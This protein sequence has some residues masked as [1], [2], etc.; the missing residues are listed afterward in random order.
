MTGKKGILYIIA[1]P[2]GNLEDI[3]LRALKVLKDVDIIACEDTRHT[4][5]LLNFYEIKKPLTSYFEHNKVTKGMFIIKKLIEGK[6][7]GLVSNAGCPGISDPGSDIVRIAREHSITVTMIPG[8]C[9]FITAFV[10]SGIS[11]ERF[12]FEGFLPVRKKLRKQRFSAIRNETGSIVLYEAPHKLLKTIKDLYD[13]L[14]ERNIIIARELT[15]KYE[16]VLKL[17]LSEAIKKYEKEQARGE[18]VITIEGNSGEAMDKP[19]ISQYDRI[20]I[21]KDVE[22]YIKKGI[23]K[24]DAIK[25]TAS[26][27]GISKRDVYQI[28]ESQ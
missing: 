26:N 6:N 28:T 16:E 14:G 13:Y 15:K 19:L 23:T 7:I 27:R 21:C 18:F 5:K 10:L 25:M 1:T 2:I 3:T 22:S 8:A 4:L 11:S 9:A 20:E 12:V 24:K 17:K